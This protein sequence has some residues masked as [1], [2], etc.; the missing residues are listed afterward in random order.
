MDAQ[1]EVERAKYVKAYQSPKYARNA[2][3]QGLKNADYLQKLVADL[4][5]KT[6]N[7]YGC[8]SGDMA[9]FMA[10]MD[11]YTRLYD[12]M[13][14]EYLKPEVQALIG[15]GKAEFE[16][17]SLWEPALRARRPADLAICTDV[18]EHIPEDR[19][20]YVLGTIYRQ[21]P[22]AFFRIA[23]YGDSERKIARNGGTLHVTVQ[24]VEW[25]LDRLIIAGFPRQ[26]E[27]WV[28]TSVKT[29]SKQVLCV[30]TGR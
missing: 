12:F 18:M 30:K 7:D 15:A 3:R 24:A 19:V 9:V 1:A 20:N 6:C 13:G 5:I 22:V 16:K 21:A 25:W 28:E 2:G 17:T 14:R 10:D 27:Y 4:R 23:M 11:V 29:A 26:V 8:G